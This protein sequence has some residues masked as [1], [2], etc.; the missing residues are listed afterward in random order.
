VALV[1]TSPPYYGMRTY[2]PD[3]WLRSWFL[4]GPPHVTYR[5]PKKELSHPSAKAFADQLRSVWRNAAA[6]AMRDARLVCRFGGIT[7]RRQDS[8]ELLKTS[9]LDSGWTLKTV[10]CAGSALDGKR[11]ATQFG[12]RPSAR[13]LKE[14]DAYACLDR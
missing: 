14:Y 13:P 8:L 7:D 3:Q 10:R 4:G 1:V 9:F 6:V 2:I 5:Q 12:S 11:Q